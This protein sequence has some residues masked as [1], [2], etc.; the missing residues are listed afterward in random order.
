MSNTDAHRRLHD[1]FNRR[2]WDALD[3]YVREDVTYQDV[4]RGQR[5]GSL[6]AF[7]EWL[8][9][10]ATG[11]SDAQVAEVAY[12]DGGD[13]TV[14]RFQGRGTNDGKLGSFEP[15]DQRMDMAFCEILH[16]DAEG[17][18]ESAEIYYDQMTMLTQ[19]GHVQPPG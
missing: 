16:W 1:F 14:A 11:F 3:K 2:D 4:P 15:T 5:M 19:L 8:G 18:V 7:K 17:Q 9:E 6:A 10:W 12:L 13:F